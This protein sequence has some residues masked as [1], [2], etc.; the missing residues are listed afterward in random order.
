MYIYIYIYIYI[1]VYNF[2]TTLSRFLISAVA[3]VVLLYCSFIQRS[4][5]SFTVDNGTTIGKDK[6]QVDQYANS[7]LLCLKRHKM[8]PSTSTVRRDLMSVIL[9]TL[10][11]NLSHEF[12]TNI[13]WLLQSHGSICRFDWFITLSLL[14][15]HKM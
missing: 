7:K 3:N 2:N 4:R 10:F 6:L 14:Y 5:Q 9:N 1:Y 8:N 15:K 11:P 12:L 13:D